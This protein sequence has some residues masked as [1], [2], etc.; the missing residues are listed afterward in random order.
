MPYRGYGNKSQIVVSGHVLENRPDFLADVGDK[1]RKNFRNMIARYMSTSIPETEVGIHFQ[2]QNH[3]ATTDELGFFQANIDLIHPLKAGWHQITYTIADCNVSG[4]VLI[5]DQ[6][7][8]FGVISDIDDTVLI[9]HA[10]QLLRK[11]RLILTKNAKTRLPFPGVKDFYCA[12][13]GD[14]SVNPIFYVS[15]SEWNLYD[16]LVDFFET[17]E[18]PKGPFLLQRFKSGLKELIKSGGGTHMHKQEK[19][20]ALMKFYPDL[21]F[22]LIGDSGQRDPEIYASI[23]NKYPGRIKA[24]YIRSIKNKQIDNEVKGIV[25][26]A[27]VPIRMVKH[28]DE[29]YRHATTIGLITEK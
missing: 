24:I 17:R 13:A 15:S 3:F 22:V 27:G 8:D 21:S 29:A 20:E 7:T 18:L 6:K 11:L 2:D 28:T 19:I 4:E 9:S 14:E 26:E 1:K 10:T 5:T 12:L 25:E 16:F 23:V